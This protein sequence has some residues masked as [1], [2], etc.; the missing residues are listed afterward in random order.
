MPGARTSSATPTTATAPWHDQTMPLAE[1]MKLA[2]GKPLRAPHDG[3]DGAAGLRPVRLQLRGLLRTRIVAKKEERLNLCVPGGKETARMLKSLYEELGTAPRRGEAA[4]AAPVAPSR[5]GA[6]AA[7]ATIPAT[8]TFL[9]R[10]RLNKRGLREGDLA[11][12]VRSRRHAASTTRSATAFGIFPTNDPALVDA[13]IKALD[14]PADFPIGGRTLREVLTDGVSL[15]ARARHAV[16][17]LS[18]TSPAASGGRRRRR[19]RRAKTRTA[20]PRRSTCSRRSRNSP[21]SGPIRKPSSRRSIRCSRG[22]IRSRPRR[23]PTRAACRSPSTP[24]A[25]RSASATRLGVASTFLAERVEPGAPL[26]VYVQKAHA[27]G[28]PA[29]PQRRS[30]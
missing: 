9:S 5:A 8:A 17:A 7:R 3:G 16:P 25:T 11:H 10:T 30:S 28:L 13:V 26:K 20:T 4:R 19:S 23:R 21:A 15:V 24:C 6:P 14:A 1:R 22:S 29:D 27:F 2:E 18:P 12:R